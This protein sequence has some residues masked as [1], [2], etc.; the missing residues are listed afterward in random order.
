MKLTLR[1]DTSDPDQEMEVKRI[2]KATDMANVLWEFTANTRRKVESI[3]EIE[4]D[5]G[6]DFNHEDAISLVFADLNKLMDEF[7]IN[8]EE[9]IN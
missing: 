5:R 3:I 9:L 1:F 8:L 4:L 6:N 7:N 2:L